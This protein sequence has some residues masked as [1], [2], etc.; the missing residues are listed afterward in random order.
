MLLS[1]KNN[2]NT[3]KTGVKEPANKHLGG[4]KENNPFSSKKPLKIN[5]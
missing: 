4:G 2:C 1:N 5:N 3:K